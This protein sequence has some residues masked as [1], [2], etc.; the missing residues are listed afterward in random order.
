[1]DGFEIVDHAADWAVRVTGSDLSQLFRQAALAMS[2]LL[3]DDLASIRINRVIH[4]ESEADDPET[5]LVDW[6]TEL[7]YYAETEQVVFREFEINTAT[8][9]RLTAIARGGRAQELQKHIKAVTYHNLEIIS[10]E[11]G[12]EATIVFD[13]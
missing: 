13:V 11:E 5:L 10:S 3:V 2:S 7:A 6:L 1:M 8:A 9:T 4:F 12:L